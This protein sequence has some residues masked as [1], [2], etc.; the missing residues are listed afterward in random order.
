MEVCLQARDTQTPTE[1]FQTAHGQS[2][3]QWICASLSSSQVKYLFKSIKFDP[4]GFFFYWFDVKF[5]HQQCLTWDRKQHVKQTMW[6]LLRTMKMSRRPSSAVQIVQHRTRVHPINWRCTSKAIW[7]SRVLDGWSILWL[8]MKTPSW[9]HIKHAE[10]AVVNI[11]YI[12][13]Q[14]YCD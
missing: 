4:F 14:Y 7:I 5:T 8:F 10:S 9:I 2:M 12:H 6:K 13:F 11:Q 3:F 1:T